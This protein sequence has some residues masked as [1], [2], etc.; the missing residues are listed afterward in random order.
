MAG[1]QYLDGLA[2]F[3]LRKSLKSGGVVASIM[4]S[5][6]CDVG[7]WRGAVNVTRVACALWRVIP[8]APS[9]VNKVT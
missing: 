1:V 6:L 3:I 8:H 4:P 5:F 7:D 2:L 9:N